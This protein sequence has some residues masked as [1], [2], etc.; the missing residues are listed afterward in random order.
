MR[1]WFPFT[2]YDFYAY[3]T[4]GVILV[5][6]F[7]YVFAGGMLTARNDWS[8]V[9][10]IFWTMIA[11][12]VGHVNSGFSATFLE[13]IL[14]K[15]I[16]VPPMEIILRRKSLG[17]LGKAFSFVFAREYGPFTENTCNIILDAASNHNNCVKKNEIDAESIFHTAFNIARYDEKSQIRLDQFMN[18][19]GFCRNVSFALIVSAIV[20]IF[21]ICQNSMP[22]T[23]WALVTSVILGIGL[24]G[25]YVKF[26]CCYTR[27]VLRSYE[28]SLP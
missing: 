5:A 10:G 12:L 15:R 4:S 14:L 19:Y 24:F 9:H 27:E 23:K 8:L 28:R 26:Y 1:S 6:A 11:Y 17:R 7:D 21:S 25:R 22:V 20:F 16:F 18:L 2:D 13:N 3:L